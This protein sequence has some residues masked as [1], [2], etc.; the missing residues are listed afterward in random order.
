MVN[1]ISFYTERMI[2]QEVSQGFRGK[3]IRVGELLGRRSDGE[4]QINF[5]SNAFVNMIKAYKVMKMFPLSQLN[6]PVEIA[7]IDSTASAVVVLAKTPR[8]AV[9][10]NAY[11]SYGLFMANIMYAFREYGFQVDFVSDDMFNSHFDEMMKNNSKSEYLSGLFY[12][13][14]NSRGYIITPTENSF[15]T[16][17][18]YR[19]DFRWPLTGDNYS[20]K[21]IEMLDGLGFF[22][23]N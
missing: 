20:I 23:E 13:G 19:Y 11:N 15:T 14:I 8:K 17:I 12:Y 16:T 18:L 1:I 9:V 5:K 21:L 10:F 7:P 4:F 22:D 2:L 3:I 6:T